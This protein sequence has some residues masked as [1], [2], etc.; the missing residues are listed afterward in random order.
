MR[1]I[2]EEKIN[3][4][5][6]LYKQGFNK[7]QISKQL[8]V[9]EDTVRKYLTTRFNVPLKDY[10]KK[11]N[12]QQ[13][14]ELWK[15]GKTD[16]EIS[17]FF[18]V[19]EST[20]KTYRTKGKNAGKFNIVRYFSQTEQKLTYEQEQFIRGSLLG[21]LNLSKPTS[22]RHINSRLSIVQCEKQKA[23]FMKKIEIL[24]D[25]MG[26]YKLI[27]PKPDP[28]T[29]KIYTSYRGNSKAHKVFT[30]LYNELYINGKKTITKEF[31][32]KITSPI[33]LAYWFMDDGTF[34]GS[35]ATNGF[36]EIE[37]DLLIKWLSEYW[38]IFSYKEKNLNNFIIRI[39]EKSRKD[40]EDLIKDYIIPEMKYKLKY[41]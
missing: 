20:V 26:N 27:T 10:S 34:N 5:F 32:D 13:F 36:S 3:Q 17:N 41:K 1:K 8:K 37:V 18:K 39:S 14:E 24:G 35:I 22:N 6:E 12:Q 2:S 7:V 16:K 23:F 38:N 9:N 19:S 4:M 21:D 15:Q 31:L 25:F 40:F 11:I 29:G 33:A 30:D 28:R